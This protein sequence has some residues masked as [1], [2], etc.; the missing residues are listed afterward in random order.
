MPAVETASGL[1]VPLMAPPSVR[2]EPRG[3]EI[4]KPVPDP[5]AIPRLIVW[6]AVALRLMRLPLSVS[7]LPPS[8]KL[9]LSAEN[10]RPT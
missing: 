10:V 1:P 5:R 8:V 2:D 4:V 3:L 6:A 9:P 7:G